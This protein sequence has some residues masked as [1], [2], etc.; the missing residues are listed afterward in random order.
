MTEMDG[1]TSNQGEQATGTP[2][3]SQMK[4]KTYPQDWPAYNAAQTSEKDHFHQ[5]LA[6]LCANV[7]QPEYTGG[8]PRLP[9]ADMV[10]AGA[11]KVYSGFSTRR[12]NCDV[13]KAQEQGSWTL[14][15]PSTRLTA[16]SATGH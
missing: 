10:F 9:L 8:R 7:A 12:F 1:I 2:E 15:R 14:R 4:R 6:D 3:P 13:R 5:L 16:I 11:A